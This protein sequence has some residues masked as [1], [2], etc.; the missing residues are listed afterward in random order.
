MDD[1]LEEVK[2]F[3]EETLRKKLKEFG[4]SIG[5]VNDAIVRRIFQKKLTK[6]IAIERGISVEENND[7]HISIESKISENGKTTDK[8][9]PTLPQMQRSAELFYSLSVPSDVVLEEGQNLIFT[10]KVEAFKTAKRLKGSRFKVFKT[11]QEAEEFC[12]R[13]AEEYASP[14]RT[15]PQI[16]VD[17]GDG[18]QK[19][20]IPVSAESSLFKGPKVQDLMKMRKMI[21]KGDLDGVKELVLSNPRYLVSSGDTPT[22]LQEGFRYNALH[23]AAKCNQAAITRFI[24]DTLETVNFVQLLYPQD[25]LDTST[26]RI[27]FLVDLY[28]NMPDKGN[29][30]TPLHFASKFGNLDVLEVLATH[31]RIQKQIKSKFGETPADVLCSRVQNV[32]KETKDKMKELLE[33]QFYV[34]LLRSDDNSTPPVISEPWSPE[35]SQSDFDY[36]GQLHSSPSQS[37]RDP[38]LNVKAFAGPMSPSKASAFHKQWMGS[39]THGSPTRNLAEMKKLRNIKYTD[40]DKGVERIGR[41][42]AAELCVSWN[43]YWDFLQCYADLTTTT[44][45]DKLEQFLREKQDMYTQEKEA[46]NIKCDDD[47]NDD[48]KDDKDDFVDCEEPADDADDTDNPSTTES[49][50]TEVFNNDIKAKQNDSIMNSSD[51]VGSL[52]SQMALLTL[53]SP[54]VVPPHS[55]SKITS[56]RTAEDVFKSIPEKDSGQIELFVDASDVFEAKEGARSSS[57][58]NESDLSKFE[59]G[60]CSS[61]EILPNDSV[62]LNEINAT[63]QN[64]KAI[65]LN[66]T[67]GGA[68]VSPLRM[69]TSRVTGG[70]RNVYNGLSNLLWSPKSKINDPSFDVIENNPIEPIS[71]PVQSN[72]TVD[73]DIPNSDPDVKVT[74]VKDFDSF[75][76]PKKITRPIEDDSVETAKQECPGKLGP[77]EHKQNI[78]IDGLFPS[79]R[80]VDV[81]RALDTVDI[82]PNTHPYISHW[83]SLVQSHSEA[84]RN[85]WPSP[86]SRGYSKLRQQYAGTP[87]RNGPSPLVEN[88]ISKRHLEGV[89]ANLM[90]SFD[91]IDSKS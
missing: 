15:N 73:S 5:P 42:L 67:P 16:S 76:T 10:D 24:L 18:P 85:R 17:V 4:V 1:I 6:F 61:H 33:D 25:S 91:A 44:G 87:L 69:L 62:N 65:Q 82:D 59:P 34:P 22:I 31:P 48:N 56:D 78:F 90:Q 70:V 36:I 86:C 52:T 74:K 30:E 55:N 71:A 20:Q 14:C 35:Q 68:A 3:D 60:Q 77:L 29:N 79:K 41:G 43:E 84:D 50:P 7:G 38:L 12:Q 57:T 83:L 53:N 27:K 58:Q 47:L 45:L 21:E 39:P 13:K 49:D 88:S 54:S 89:Q 19:P 26:S 40:P 64:V 75:D 28:I 72:D 37:P 23:V 2:L 8:I 46:Q 81:C 11:I 63:A 51:G 80:D 66:P 9:Q 32:S